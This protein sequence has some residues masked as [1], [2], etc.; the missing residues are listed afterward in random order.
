MT[1]SCKVGNNCP[2]CDNGFCAEPAAVNIDENGMCSF[3]WRKGQRRPQY[4]GE[5]I[6]GKVNVIDADEKDLN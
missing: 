6:V 4:S 3:I 5:Y 2:Y 1:V